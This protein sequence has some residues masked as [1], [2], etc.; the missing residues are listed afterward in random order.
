M[1]SDSR[2]RMVRSAAYLLREHGYSG[3]AFSDV[4][5]HSGA[6][7]GSIYHHFPGGKEQLA[8]EAVRYAGDF[9]AA[10]VRAATRD[11]DPVA[12]VRAFSG[13]WRRVLVD[14]DF[15]AGCPIVA[16]ITESRLAD[17][18]AA[19]FR[20]WQDALAAGLVSAGA[21]PERAARV[22]TLVTASAEGATLLCRARRS[23]EPFDDVVAELEDLIASACEKG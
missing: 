3:T 14:S 7:R 22:A 18:A 9:V 11:D 5:A 19:A 21:T 6:P 8:E 12:A 20:R 23:L 15:R 16:V 13:W 17:A 1:A 10:G 2:E 4:I